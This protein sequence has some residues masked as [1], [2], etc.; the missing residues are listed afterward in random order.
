MINVEKAAY[1]AFKEIIYGK[2]AAGSTSA[3]EPRLPLPQEVFS[4]LTVGQG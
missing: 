4:L 2:A 3:V 1:E